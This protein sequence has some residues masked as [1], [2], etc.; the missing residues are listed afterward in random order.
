VTLILL[1]LFAPTLD[2]TPRQSAR[3]SV[4]EVLELRLPCPRGHPEACRWELFGIDAV[5]LHAAGNG[6]VCGEYWIEVE[7]IES[8]GEEPS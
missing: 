7:V 3:L 2:L 5:A 1:A 8:R 4:G 6:R